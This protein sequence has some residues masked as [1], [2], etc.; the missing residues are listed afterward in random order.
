M[1]SNYPVSV[2][3]DASLI[4]PKYSPGLLLEDHDLTL[5]V[6][7]ARALNRMLLRAMLGAGVLCGLR[8][9]ADAS[10][11]CVHITVRRGIAIDASGALIELKSDAKVSIDVGCE[12]RTATLNF[13]IVIERTQ[14][15]CEQRDI[16]CSDDDGATVATR[17]VDGYAIH[18][19]NRDLGAAWS[20]KHTDPGDDD[21]LDD[22]SHPPKAVLLAKLTYNNGAVE[23]LHGERSYVRPAQAPD[24]IVDTGTEAP[25]E[26]DNRNQPGMDRAPA[27]A[28][29]V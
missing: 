5:A 17:L 28:I 25:V 29:G 19:F 26:T 13:A 22:C 9:T 1:S 3:G 21:C 7:Y 10:N 6:D 27:Q 16:S 15:P 23:V 4:R 18:V 8:V 20:R 12:N 2:T 14:R 11:C 24:P